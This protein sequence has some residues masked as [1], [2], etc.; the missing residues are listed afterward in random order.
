MDK[1]IEKKVINPKK[2]GPTLTLAQL[3]E[4]Q[5]QLFDAYAVYHKFYEFK[6]S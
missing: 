3:Y 1:N 2:L 4:S 5:N 6:Q